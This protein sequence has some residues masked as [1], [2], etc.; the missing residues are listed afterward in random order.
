[1]NFSDFGNKLCSKSG[2]LQLMDD[3][4]RPLPK[5]V[6]PYRLGGGNPAMIPEIS[7]MYRNEMN[8]IMQNGDEFE[9]LIGLYDSPQGRMLFIETVAEYLSKAYGWNITAEN[10][11]ITNGSQSACFYLFNLLSGTFTE[12]TNTIK[13][14]VVFPLA[15]EYIGY[16]DQSIEEDTFVSI[17]ATW[18]EYGEN[19]FKYHVNFDL[20]EDYMQKNHN[21][22]ALCVTR[23]TNPTGNV[24]TDDEIEK[25][26]SISKRYM[27]PLVI[28]NAYGLPWPNI[29]FTDSATPYYDENI[30]LS[31]SLSK[32]G[33]PSLRTGIIIAPKQIVTALSNLNAIASLASGSF[34]QALAE[35]LIKN[36][37]LVENAKNFVRPYYE[38]KSKKALESFKRHF[39]STPY[40][41]HKSE[42]SIFQ[43]LLMKDLKIPTLEFYSRLKEKGV[44]VVPGEYFF[45][46]NDKKFL[47]PIEN[48]PHY[49]KCLRINYGGDEKE[50]DEGIKIIAETYKNFM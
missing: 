15:P 29:I 50:V 2:I 3:I 38:K 48:H 31:M 9:K 21:I 24:L 17:P 4:G 43:W 39:D 37:T 28:D 47:P 11:A 1:M 44:I 13:K 42:G 16:C 46:G 36:G 45:F 40:S 25:L 10:V 32:I 7:A 23:P 41:V 49:S 26:S 30:I 6:K 18:Q 14:K 8:K 35:D 33:L 19:S 20:L 27:I 22:G 34:G 5:G 12:G